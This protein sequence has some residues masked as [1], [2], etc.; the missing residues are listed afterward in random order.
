MYFKN[1]AKICLRFDVNVRVRGWANISNINIIM[2]LEGRV[3]IM[4]EGFV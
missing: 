4:G 1:K 3:N 2:V